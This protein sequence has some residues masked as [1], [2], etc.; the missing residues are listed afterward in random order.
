MPPTIYKPSSKE[1]EWFNDSQAQ[2][3]RFISDLG[4]GVIDW[5]E[6]IQ[7][8]RVLD[9]GCGD[10]VLAERIANRGC[11]VV[12]VDSDDY[13]VGLSRDKGIETYLLNGLDMTF[14][15]EFTAVFSNDSLHTFVDQPEILKPINR[16][17]KEDG[18]FVGELGGFGN[19]AAIISTLRAIA[20]ERKLDETMAHPWLFPTV[21]EY[22]NL[23]E[24]CGFRVDR[25]IT[26]ARPT[27]LPLDLR[28]WLEITFELY[29]NQL[30]P[31]KRQ[32]AL[33]LVV[34]ALEPVMC[35]SHGNWLP[36]FVRLRFSAVKVKDV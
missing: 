27:V 14:Q 28:E 12:G 3:L 31:A 25:I 8:D 32:D 10:G 17:L 22:S 5:L 9:L 26:F 2:K 29:F 15:N 16:A 7:G 24:S 21:E 13:L 1:K 36:D 23:L 19:L 20:L 30:D 11:E 4:L 33:D 18:R 6:P 35:D 34:N